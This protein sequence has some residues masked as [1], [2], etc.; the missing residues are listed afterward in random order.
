MPARVLYVPTAHGGNGP[1]PDP[2][3]PGLPTQ[4]L[5]EVL[6]TGDVEFCGHSVHTVELAT[7]NVPAAHSVHGSPMGPAYPALQAMGILQVFPRGQVVS[8]RSTPERIA[9]AIAAVASVFRYSSTTK[10]PAMSAL[11]TAFDENPKAI[12][13]HFD[14]PMYIPAT[15]LSLITCGSVFV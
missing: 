13:C 5:I 14:F 2:V 15:V 12:V 9:S 8:V 3:Y 4:A 7:A 10:R 6:E 11:N 1:A